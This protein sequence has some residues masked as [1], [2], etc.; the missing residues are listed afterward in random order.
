MPP[1]P[2]KR[3]PVPAGKVRLQR[4]LAAA[5]VAARRAAEE[6][7]ENG[8][9]TVNGRTVSRLPVFVD[10]GEDRISVDG[11]PIPKAQRPVY[12][13]VNKPERML[14]V[15]ADEPGL[16]R[17]TVLDLIDHPA[18]PRLVPV[19]RL[20]WTTTG[21]I[22]LTNDG[23]AVNRLTHPR[24]GVTKTYRAAVRG[25]LDEAAVSTV[26]SRIARLIKKDDRQSGRVRPGTAARPSAGRIQME[27]EALHPDRTDLL[28]TLREGRTGNLAKML[29]GAGVSV[30]K[31]ER[32]AIGPIE[33]RALARGRWRELD[34]TEIAALRA[35]VKGK[36]T[37]RR[38]PKT[39]DRP[40]RRGRP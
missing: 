12:I 14:T 16:D 31:L 5:G 29:A 20:D 4:V 34:R 6:L 10:P 21:L 26:Q 32:I 30:K 19:G 18:R 11:R 25:K 37:E 2:Q 38:R 3:D 33:L 1:G 7:I 15:A 24:Y 8:R 27:I 9:V 23:E 39:T 28:I 40:R 17:A 36:Q 22:L 13:M 35:A